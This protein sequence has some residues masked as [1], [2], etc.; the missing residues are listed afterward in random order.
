M[1]K[2]PGG[3]FTDGN[4]SLM[5]SHGDGAQRAVVAQI[6]PHP[7]LT[8]HVLHQISRA[9]CCASGCHGADQILDPLAVTLGG[10]K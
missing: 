10:E 9:F 5:G 3:A 1:I 6:K 2:G 8:S 4:G 7:N